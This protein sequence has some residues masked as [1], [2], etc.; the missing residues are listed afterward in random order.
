M[1]DLMAVQ[2]SRKKDLKSWDDL[3]DSE[4][5]AYMISSSLIIIIYITFFFWALMRAAAAPKNKPLHLMF[6]LVS[7]MFYLV[8]SYFIDGF[9]D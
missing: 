4:K 2:N 3:S 9:Y 1:L 6:A 7:P 8:F 5:N